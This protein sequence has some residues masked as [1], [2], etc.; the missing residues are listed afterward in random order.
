MTPRIYKPAQTGMQSGH[1][2]TKEWVLD[3]EP[4][5]MTFK[6]CSGRWRGRPLLQR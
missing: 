5:N 2:K 4:A 6:A 3:Y 1:A